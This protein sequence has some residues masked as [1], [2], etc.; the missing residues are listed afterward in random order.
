MIISALAQHPT[1]RHIQDAAALNAACADAKR[2]TNKMGSGAVVR[3]TPRRDGP[4]GSRAES[5]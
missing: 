3:S 2:G 4:S 1:Q 5:L